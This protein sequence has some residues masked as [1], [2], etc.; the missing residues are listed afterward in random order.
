M[1]AV[2]VA[3]VAA[4]LTART[5]S[6]QAPAAAQD[7]SLVSRVLWAFP[8]TSRDLPSARAPF[9]SVTPIHLPHST[10]SFTMAQA[11][12]VNAPPDWYPHSHPP[13]PPSVAQGQRG[14]VWACGYCH[15]PDGQ[16]RSENAVLSGLPAA[17]MER[18]VAAIRAGTRR[19]ALVTF[20][21]SVRM[22]EVADSATVREVRE[23]ARY[24]SRI[25]A[26]PRFAV[27]ERATIP[28]TYEANGLYAIRAGA[29]SQP[30]GQR[31]IE[32]TDDLVRHELRDAN[33]TFTAY[34]PVGSVA[35]GR[36]IARGKATAITT[37][38]TCHGPALRGLALAPPIAGRSP[39]Y[40]FRQLV[41]FRTGARGGD[42]SAAMQKVVAGLSVDDMIAVAA[43][44]GSLRPSR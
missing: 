3:M 8:G 15:L 31:I 18:Q 1:R 2:F 11:K 39:S 5:S 14:R 32:V 43:Y 12:N 38:T 22:H 42:A 21:A 7:T 36:R 23:A 30:L 34:V 24:F 40:L 28:A 37:C 10:Q 19:G 17:Y 33:A 41:G 35:A 25:R 9:D 44:A 26:R 13:M 20:S 29:D 4:C 27:V 16:G 6:A